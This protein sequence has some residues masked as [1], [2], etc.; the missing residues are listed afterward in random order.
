M[1]TNVFSYTKQ[2]TVSCILNVKVSEA[3]SYSWVEIICLK[4]LG[5]DKSWEEGLH[6]PYGEMNNTD[7]ESVVTVTRKT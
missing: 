6:D 5:T 2:Y 1:F 4:Y 3:I 7:I